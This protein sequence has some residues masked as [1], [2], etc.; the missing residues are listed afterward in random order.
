VPELPA[1]EARRN[2]LLGWTEATA[3]PQVEVRCSTRR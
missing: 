2:E 1:G 3:T